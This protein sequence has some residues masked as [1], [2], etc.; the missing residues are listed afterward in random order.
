VALLGGKNGR[1]AKGVGS[2]GGANVVKP[3]LVAEEMLGVTGREGGGTGTPLF[4]IG[5]TGE[6]FR[7]GGGRNVLSTGVEDAT[8]T[9]GT[10]TVASLRIDIL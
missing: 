9:G 6:S 4:T 2:G 5:I 3:A 7:N 10:V 8:T 1:E